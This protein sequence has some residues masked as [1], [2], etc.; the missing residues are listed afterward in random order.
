V[1]QPLPASLAEL[2]Q[3]FEKIR[4]GGHPCLSRKALHEKP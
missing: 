2:M 4:A 3:R 1:E